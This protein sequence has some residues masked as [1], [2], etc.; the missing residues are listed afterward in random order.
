MTCRRCGEPTTAG[1]IRPCAAWRPGGSVLC[2]PWRPVMPPA[3]FAREEG[4]RLRGPLRLDEDLGS[5][6]ERDAGAFER[7]R[8]SDDYVRV[9]GSRMHVDDVPT[10]A[11]L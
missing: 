10:A 6:T 5:R 8:T 2:K 9:G 4:R 11:E 3:A 7:R 1:S